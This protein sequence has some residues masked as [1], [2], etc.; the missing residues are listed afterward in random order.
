MGGVGSM[1]GQLG[2]CYQFAANKIT[3]DYS[4]ADIA[5][6]PW[7]RVVDGFYGAGELASIDDFKCVNAWVS[8]C[9][10]RPAS[11]VGL[12]TRLRG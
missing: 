9:E 2:H 3:D 1:F 12:Y 8:R 5:T 4:I 11:K 10:A 7:V 6:F